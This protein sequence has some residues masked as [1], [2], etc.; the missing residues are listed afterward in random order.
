[1]AGCFS[2]GR[3]VLAKIRAVVFANIER[4]E[5]HQPLALQGGLAIADKIIS[6]HGGSIRVRDNLPRGSAFTVEIPIR[7]S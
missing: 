1:M 4:R 6:E 5:N 7:E 3:L 2:G